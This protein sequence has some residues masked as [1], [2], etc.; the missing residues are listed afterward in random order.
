MQKF[1]HFL[2][3]L[4]HQ[5]NKL[6]LEKGEKL[7]QSL[8]AYKPN[9]H[10][11]KLK[12]NYCINWQFGPFLEFQSFNVDHFGIVTMFALSPLLLQTIMQVHAII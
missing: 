7:K 10:P 6:K 9:A 5:S 11:L 1:L 4:I 8:Q 12:C 3:Q 2:R